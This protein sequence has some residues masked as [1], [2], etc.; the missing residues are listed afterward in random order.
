MASRKPQFEASS[1]A[2]RRVAELNSRRPPPW[3]S[4]ELEDHF[5]ATEPGFLQQSA[6]HFLGRGLAAHRKVV[7]D[8]HKS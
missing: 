3:R 6:T 7:L 8:T 4:I 2:R 5:F 1:T